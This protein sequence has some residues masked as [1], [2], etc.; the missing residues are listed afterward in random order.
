MCEFLHFPDPGPCFHSNHL[1]PV[2]GN[3]T[4]KIEKERDNALFYGGDLNTVS[5]IRFSVGGK[6]GWRMGG[7]EM[8]ERERET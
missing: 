4:G 5:Y 2:P 1:A 8:G 6:E 7:R 3:P